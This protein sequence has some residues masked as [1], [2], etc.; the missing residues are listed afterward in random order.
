MLIPLGIL[1][2]SRAAGF[3]YRLQT[4]GGAGI[5]YGYQIAIDSENN[6]YAVGA[7][8]SAGSGGEDLLLVKYDSTGAIQWQ[9]ALGGSSTE[10]GRGIVLDSAN[11]IYVLGSTNS[12]PGTLAD[13]LVA[14]YDSNGTIQWQ[15]RLGTSTGANDFGSGIAIDSSGNPHIA[16]A[17]ESVGFGSYDFYFARMS[18]TGSIQS[19][20]TIGRPAYDYCTGIGVDAADNIYLIGDSNW[21]T[22]GIS[23]FLLVK[24]SP[25][26]S[27]LWQRRMGGNNL[28]IGYRVAFDSSG[29]VYA[30]GHS[31]SSGTFGNRDVILV[32]YNSSGSIQWQRRL[33]GSQNEQGIAVATDS[34]GGVYVAGYTASTGAG[35]E[36]VLIAKYDTSGTIQWQRVLGGTGNERAE[37]IA[38]D[39]MGNLF[40]LGETTSAGAGG[41]DLLL[42]VL[43]S[44]GSLTGT[45]VLNGA[46]ITYAASSLSSA[47]ST[48]TE[49]SSSLLTDTY[50]L[51]NSTASFTSASISLTS[52]RTDI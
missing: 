21:S 47:A 24:I 9:R 12:T 35:G 2:A 19:Q 26:G 25:T 18:P 37:S 42:A 3:V 20:R 34:S 28:T 45:Y 52:H 38:F 50:A 1:S 41:R 22:S 36:D 40:V 13:I 11:N 6:F 51:S 39:S 32:K 29:N 8:S 44:D 16:G 7:T 10:T 49:A 4:L 31:N 27:I 15:R 48:L 33:G 14:K 46:N 23:D 5:E 43:P 17:T 30:T